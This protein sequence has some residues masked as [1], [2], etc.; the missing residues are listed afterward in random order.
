MK[1]KADKTCYAQWEKAKHK[2]TKWLAE[3]SHTYENRDKKD[4]KTLNN[5]CDEDIRVWEEN[6]D[7]QMDEANMTHQTKAMKRE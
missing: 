3:R 2:K 5:K 4:L 1:T 7:I 6:H